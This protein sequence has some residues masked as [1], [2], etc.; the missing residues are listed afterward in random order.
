MSGAIFNSDLTS[1]A[2]F[3]VHK[4]TDYY[5]WKVKALF[6]L[7]FID[8]DGVISS[9]HW[10]RTGVCDKRFGPK[11]AADL[12]TSLCTL[13]SSQARQERGWYWTKGSICALPG[14]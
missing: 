6:G 3:E 5:V 11:V 13:L 10:E 12:A 8:T 2:V 14:T 9:S 1:A 4:Q 7:S